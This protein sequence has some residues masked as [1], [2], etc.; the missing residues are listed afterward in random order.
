MKQ[1]LK[2]KENLPLRFLLWPENFF[3][4]VACTA[5]T[6]CFFDDSNFCKKLC[7]V[8]EKMNDCQFTCDRLHCTG[9]KMQYLMQMETED[10]LCPDRVHNK[11]P[12]PYNS[13]VIKRAVIA[14]SKGLQYFLLPHKLWLYDA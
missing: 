7:L 11:S 3:P 13:L 1:E 10:Q 8:S 5:C 9:D 14:A 12:S 2:L 6:A 4:V